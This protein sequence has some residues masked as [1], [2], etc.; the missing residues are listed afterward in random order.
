MSESNSSSNDSDQPTTEGG[1][2]VSRIRIDDLPVAENLT[3]EQEELIEGAGLKSFRPTLEALEDRKL[4][5]AGMIAGAVL[6][7]DVVV[8][9]QTPA[10]M[11]GEATPRNNV[12]QYNNAVTNQGDVLRTNAMTNDGVNLRT[13]AMMND[14]PVT[15]NAQQAMTLSGNFNNG[16]F[17]NDQL[18][19]TAP[20]LKVTNIPDGTQSL[21]VI[22][23]DIS[24][25][26]TRK[27]DRLNNGEVYDDPAGKWTHWAVYNI[28]RSEIGAN[29]EISLAALQKG[30]TAIA[31]QGPS[32]PAGETHAYVFTAFALNKD[33]T[34]EGTR[35]TERD[36]GMRV[37]DSNKSAEGM[38][39]AMQQAV[40]RDMGKLDGV[41]MLAMAQ[42]EVTYGDAAQ[43]TRRNS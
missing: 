5:N 18:G 26:P 19:T 27:T 9:S 34:V 37:M 25:N 8:Q 13:N 1:V 24:V 33:I 31:Y 42:V 2:P 22:G 43:V 11:V 30:R 3:P 23:E 7:N 35:Y 17:T 21:M 39:Q 40:E 6:R 28:P 16:K 15:R 4:M 10:G 14:G 20:T 32:P 36:G 41:K 38:R 12:F 29:G